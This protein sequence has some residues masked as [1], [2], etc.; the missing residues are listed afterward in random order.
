[1]DLKILVHPIV[2]KIV[3]LSKKKD[4]GKM[5]LRGIGEHCG[6]EDSPQ[7]VKHH[8]NQ[9]VKMGVFDYIAGKYIKHF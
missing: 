2:K 9:L 8:L 5:T 1:M 7:Q 6:A 4:I 3:D